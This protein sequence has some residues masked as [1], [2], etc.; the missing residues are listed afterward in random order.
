MVLFFSRSSLHA[1]SLVAPT[2][3]VLSEVVKQAHLTESHEAKMLGGEPH[4][5]IS[6][7][8]LY[9]YAVDQMA[10]TVRPVHQIC[11]SAQFP[12]C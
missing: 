2:L 5:L 11:S 6:K 7:L 3:Q 10:W 12:S 4:K 8:G 9:V 1:P